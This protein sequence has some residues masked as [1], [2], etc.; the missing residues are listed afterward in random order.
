MEFVTPA[1]SARPSFVDPMINDGSSPIEG[2]GLGFISDGLEEV[3]E[4]L[5][6]EEE[7]EIGAKAGV[8]KT[9][10]PHL[11]RTQSEHS[12]D[13]R[14]RSLP[15][16]SWQRKSRPTSP[17]I[18]STD[19]ISVA[20]SSARSPSSSPTSARFPSLSSTR[21]EPISPTETIVHTRLVS[22]THLSSSSSLHNDFLP[23]PHEVGYAE[24]DHSPCAPTIDKRREP[25]PRPKP[26]LVDH[27]AP[28]SDKTPLHPAEKARSRAHQ[29]DGLPANVPTGRDPAFA[30]GWPVETRNR[31]GWGSMVDKERGHVLS[32]GMYQTGEKEKFTDS[33]AYWLGLYF[34]FNLGL[35]LFNKFVLVSFPFPYVSTVIYLGK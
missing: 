1:N 29:H 35:T 2:I 25:G 15:S 9:L 10:R 7:V 13:H 28:I 33:Q 27:S 34:F 18:D 14:H 22:P 12:S 21:P 20:Y 16:S 23:D 5:I 19:T 4:I 3:R 11:Q 8:S 32:S 24:T 31:G 17:Y 30:R 26:Y 6:E